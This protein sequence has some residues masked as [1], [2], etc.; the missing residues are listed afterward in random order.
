MDTAPIFPDDR[1]LAV[2]FPKDALNVLPTGDAQPSSSPDDLAD[3]ADLNPAEDGNEGNF[4]GTFFNHAFI[5]VCRVF[6]SINTHCV[7]QVSLL[8]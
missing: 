2:V 6:V 3:H 1:P 8:M 7:L 5:V 4:T